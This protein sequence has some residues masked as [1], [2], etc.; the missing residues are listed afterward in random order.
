MRTFV[1]T[2]GESYGIQYGAKPPWH[3]RIWPSRATHG[4]IFIDDRGQG[5]T[6][7]TGSMRDRIDGFCEPAFEERGRLQA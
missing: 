3:E 1:G 7:A 5:K 2:D 6:P 4:G